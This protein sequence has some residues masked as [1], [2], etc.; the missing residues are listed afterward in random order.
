M[1][2]CVCAS[3]IEGVAPAVILFHLTGP[4]SFRING[5]THPP[6]SRRLDHVTVIKLAGAILRAHHL[7]NEYILVDLQVD[8]KRRWVS[9]GACGAGGFLRLDVVSD[10]RDDVVTLVHQLVLACSAHVDGG[11]AHNDDDE[12]GR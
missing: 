3:P 7:V 1:P 11:A 9:Y 5:S 6:C 8:S 2:S 4:L 10:F 12:P